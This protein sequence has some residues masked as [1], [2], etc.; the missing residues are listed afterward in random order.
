MTET[1][2]TLFVAFLA[3]SAEIVEVDE[4]LSAPIRDPKDVQILQT[5]ISGN[6]GGMGALSTLSIADVQAIARQ[7]TRMR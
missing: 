7:K 6:S 2:I 5:A 3:A 4:T 1:D